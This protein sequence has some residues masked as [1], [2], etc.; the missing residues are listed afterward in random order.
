MC[1]NGKAVA[2]SAAVKPPHMHETGGYYGAAEDLARALGV[3]AQIAADKKSVRV[4][5]KAVVA[6][7]KEARG[8]HTHDTAVFVPIKEFA[9]AAGFRVTVD[10][11]QHTVSIRK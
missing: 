7:S 11:K 8:V 6:V 5:G 1:V 4:G 9:E 3:N 2:W 10:A